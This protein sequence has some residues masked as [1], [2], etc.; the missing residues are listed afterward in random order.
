[1]T[2]PKAPEPSVI[3]QALHATPGAAAR[4]ALRWF[5]REVI[6]TADIFTRLAISIVV[7]RG[8]AK[9]TSE[10]FFPKELWDQ[11]DQLLKGFDGE[12]EEAVTPGDRPKLIHEHAGWKFYAHKQQY[13]GQI[14]PCPLLRP[15]PCVQC[16]WFIPGL[17]GRNWCASVAAVKTMHIEPYK[18]MTL[19]ELKDA[20]VQQYGDRRT[21]NGAGYNGVNPGRVP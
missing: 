17:D 21:P 15:E 9:L 19:Y 3:L 5:G 18:S 8:I 11:G 20:M 6:W 1:M 16:E 12:E 14:W 7:F 10:W 4:G 2:T 13:Q